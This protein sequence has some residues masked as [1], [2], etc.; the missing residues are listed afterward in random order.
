MNFQ[1]FA[2]DVV[3]WDTYKKY[4]EPDGQFE[5]SRITREDVVELQGGGTG[6]AQ[7]DGTSTQSARFWFLGPGTGRQDL[8]GQHQGAQSK[9]GLVFR[10]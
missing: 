4:I 8:R 10:N 1:S 6:F 2:G 3:L 7:H 5:S 9:G